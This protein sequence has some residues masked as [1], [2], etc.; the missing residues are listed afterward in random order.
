MKELLVLKFHR[1]IG[2]HRFGSRPST[3][4]QPSGTSVRCAYAMDV[5]LPSMDK[6]AITLQ[7]GEY[8]L[9]GGYLDAP[10]LFTNLPTKDSR[11]FIRLCTK[12]RILRMFFS[13]QSLKS[14]LILHR[15]VEVIA[16]GRDEQT[17][18]WV[19]PAAS[20]EDEETVDALGAERKDMDRPQAFTNERKR[21]RYKNSLVTVRPMV[22]VSLRFSC[23]IQYVKVLT[24]RNKNEAP[25]VEASAA[26]FRAMFCWC[27]IEEAKTQGASPPS[28]PSLVPPPRTGLCH[29]EYFRS[30]RKCWTK[31]RKKADQKKKLNKFPGEFAD[32]KTM[33]CI[34]QMLGRP[35]SRA[36]ELQAS[37]DSSAAV[38]SNSACESSTHSEHPDELLAASP[39]DPAETQF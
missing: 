6:F 33:V 14:S 35:R 5:E 22:E 39:S 36:V 25:F 13:G 4:K 32:Q 29:T 38:E 12:N 23:E 17:D 1:M 9:R 26:A 3:C 8:L 28:T 30:D 2:L 37:S 21:A 31:K 16:H 18:L 7:T 27:R 11:S 15:L 34:R 20:L 24:V 10:R 19:T